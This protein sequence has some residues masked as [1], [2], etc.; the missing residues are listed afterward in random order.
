MRI[1]DS[2]CHIEKGLADY[3][4][5]TA[6]RNIIFNTIASYTEYKAQVLPTDVISIIFDYKDNWEAVKKTASEEKVK[7]LKIHSRIQKI[8]ADDY[9]VLIEKLEEIINDKPLIIDAMY[10]GENLAYQPNL[11]NIISIAR[12]FKNKPVIVAHSGGYEVLKYFYHLKTLENI[13]FDLSLSLSYLQHSSVFTDYKNLL[14]FGN[15]DKI[16]FGTDY[17][18]INPAN[19]LDVFMK[20]CTELNLGESEMDKVLFSNSKSLFL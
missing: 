12:K 9:P 13:Y 15:K 20:V 10:Y 19:H 2:H 6:G 8:T 17:P 18:L 1:F 3:N 14:K 7:A 5:E 4:I 16:I 11:A